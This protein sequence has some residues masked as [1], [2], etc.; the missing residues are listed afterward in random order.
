MEGN[1]Y[2]EPR[3]GTGDELAERL[4]QVAR[5]LE[6]QNDPGATLVNVVRAAVEL[7][8]GAA[9]ASISLIE[10]RR[11]EHAVAPAVRGGR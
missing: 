6:Q 10:G 2:D 3:A 1:A 5:D 4:S 8:P 9:D 11:R 7:V